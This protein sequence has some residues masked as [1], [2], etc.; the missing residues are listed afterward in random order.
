MNIVSRAGLLTV[1]LAAVTPA[2][3]ADN[4]GIERL[5]MCQDSWFE[6][7]SSDPARL[8]KFIESFRSDFSQKTGARRIPCSKIEP[9]RCWTSCCAGV[10]RERRHGG[11]LLGRGQREFRQ[12][13][14]EPRKK[15]RQVDQE[16]R[17]A[18]R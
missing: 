12:D 3:A 7:K 1:L 9:D 13:E 15:A 17:T 11:W 16:M 2:Q 6:W 4:P 18:Q 10:P 14:I 8:Q 5:A